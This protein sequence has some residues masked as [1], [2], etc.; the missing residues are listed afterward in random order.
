M[1][2]I[3]NIQNTK[4]KESF[5]KDDKLETKLRRIQAIYGQRSL[6][7]CLPIEFTNYLGLS[8]GDYVKCSI[9][10]N[11]LIVEKADF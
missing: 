4:T 7:L 10:D 3:I 2:K 6:L 1:N 11:Q 8:K 9:D 5:D